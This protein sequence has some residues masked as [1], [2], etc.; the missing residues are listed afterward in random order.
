MLHDMTYLNGF[1]VMYNQCELVSLKWYVYGLAPDTNYSEKKTSSTKVTHPA[2]NTALIVYL[3]RLQQRNA[4]CVLTE[5]ASQE[6]P[7]ILLNKLWVFIVNNVHSGVPAEPPTG[8]CEMSTGSW[9]NKANCLDKSI[10]KHFFAA[11]ASNL[12]KK[13]VAREEFI[14]TEDGFYKPND[15]KFIFRCPSLT[16][17]NHVEVYLEETFPTPAFQLHFQLS[18]SSRLLI[19]TLDVVRRDDSSSEGDELGDPRCSWERLMGLPSQ[20][21]HS[22]VDVW[23]SK[24]GLVPRIIAQ[25]KYMNVVPWF[26]TVS[27]RKHQRR[28][29]E[30]D[31]SGDEDE[32]KK[33]DNEDDADEEEDSNHLETE[34]ETDEILR[35]PVTSGVMKTQRKRDSADSSETEESFIPVSPD[36]HVNTPLAAGS[37]V[38]MTLP[39]DDELDLHFDSEVKRFK[40]RRK[41]HKG[42][43][44]MEPAIS[45]TLGP[46]KLNGTTSGM[47]IVPCNGRKVISSSFAQH[48][49][50]TNPSFIKPDSTCTKLKK[51]TR[52][53]SVAVSLVE[54]LSHDE[55]QEALEG[56]PVKTHPLLQ[57]LQEYVDEE[58]EMTEKRYSTSVSAKIKY[59]PNAKTFIPPLQRDNVGRLS[60]NR[61]T[62]EQLRRRL[63]SNRFDYWKSK[64]TNLQY[65]RN[66]RQAKKEQQRRLL[67]SSLESKLEVQELSKRIGSLDQF[68]LRDGEISLG[69][70]MSASDA[71]V[72]WRQE[73]NGIEMWSAHTNYR[74]SAASAADKSDIIDR[75][76]PYLQSLTLLLRKEDRNERELQRSARDRRWMSFEEF[77]RATTMSSDAQR[78]DCCQVEEPKVCVSSLESSYQVEPAIISEYLLRDLHPVVAP[79]PIDYV[80]VCPQ[81]PSQW[82]ACLALSYFTCFRSMY[83]QC[84]MGDLASVDLNQVEGNHYVTVIASNGL[85]LVECAESVSDPFANFRAAGD[86]LHPILSSGAIK[87][88]QAFSRSAVATV[89]YLVVPFRRSDVKHKMW[90]LGAFS[91]GLFGTQDIDKVSKWKPSVTIEMLFLDD[92]YEVDVNPSPFV[93]MPNCFGLYDRVCENLTLKPCDGVVGVTGRSRFLSERLYH[94]A[95]WRTKTSSLDPDDQTER[96]FI[97]V[98]YLLSQ[99]RKWIACSCTDAVGSV[100]ETH[101]F[102]VKEKENGQGLEDALFKMMQNIV[103]FY[104]LFNEISELVITRLAGL[105][106]ASNLDDE[107]Q[108]AWKQ[109]RSN[110]LAKLISPTH[111]SLFSRI[112]LVQLTAVSCEEVQLHES[113]SS[114]TLYASDEVGF[115]VISPQENIP[116]RDSSRAV[117]YTGSDAWKSTTLMPGQHLLTHKREARILKAALVLVLFEKKFDAKNENVN[118]SASS[119]T[120]TIILRDFHAL[121]YLTMHPITM[122]RQSPLPYH[123]AAISKICRELQALETQLTTDPLQLRRH[124]AR[125]VLFL[126]S[127]CPK[128]LFEHD[129]KV[130]QNK[131]PS[132]QCCRQRYLQLADNMRGSKVIK[133]PVLGRRQ[134]SVSDDNIQNF[135]SRISGRN[136]VA[137]QNTATSSLN[138][139]RFASEPRKDSVTQLNEELARRQESYV[140]R[141]RQYKIRIGELEALLS[142]SRA[143][144]SKED[145]LEAAMERVRSMHRDILVSVNQV[146]DRT[147]EI[148]QEQ[149]KDLLR[150]FRARLFSVQEELESEKNR[151]DDGASAWIEKSKHLEN[152]VEWTKDLA[153]RLDRLNQSLTRENQRL[154]TQFATQ[155]NDREFLIK[156]LVTVKKDNASLRLE[157]GS[158]R[159]QLEELNSVQGQPLRHTFLPS[160]STSSLP[161]MRHCESM[162]TVALAKRPNTAELNTMTVS[163]QDNRYKEVIKRLKRLLEVERRKLQQVRAAY[164][165]ELQS[166]SELEAILRECVKDV[167]KETAY[168]SQLP[169]VI[170]SGEKRSENRL[171]TSE[172]QELVEKLMTKNQVLKLLTIKVFPARNGKHQMITMLKGKMGEQD[173]AINL[174][175]AEVSP[176]P[177]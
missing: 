14:L 101:V 133:P 86:V 95:D 42:T 108:I 51:D 173:D 141:E 24:D 28:T 98:S 167:R 125:N 74:V 71:M 112:L 47:K 38:L 50:S 102:P 124:D 25:T 63:Y 79:K 1:D 109:L 27:K 157:V 147:S 26:R 119:S 53:L 89:V 36:T 137:D 30:N 121:T 117:Y 48:M 100:L 17:L 128:I 104:L 68:K 72:T 166:H 56:R 114:T 126:G 146:Q 78:L 69:I 21:D 93:L 16:K 168:V 18:N 152:E 70:Q 12:S 155:E 58:S 172:R 115:V 142:D 96:P 46:I 127:K 175:S 55:Q 9:S 144:K 5:N 19:M 161:K 65:S 52:P 6:I 76:Q 165:L 62:A 22:V 139:Y 111:K 31:G 44:G 140:R 160:A 135:R 171:S 34:V 164:T 77:I 129:D 107:E 105:A 80:I 29:N 75:V 130:S 4:I 37:I 136:L 103:E 33:D 116:A 131:V 158:L 67:L 159:Q 153:D 151:T 170:S 94:L 64:Y 7:K 163:N 66:G 120:M 3:Q 57:A 143:K 87:K 32:V 88:K 73:P 13:L 60:I 148:L 90:V 23:H 132:S 15:A 2:E 156:Q 122:E 110:R 150:A 39:H 92:L 49:M 177:R 145:N 162:A 40:R 35:R 59:V 113:L 43:M 54:S 99:D 123:L 154:K 176:L 118:Q 169:P 138:E 8:V 11:L 174:H 85:V 84:H 61:A 45:L 20:K 106:G 91:S 97:H 41:G 82:L 10:Q 83:G 149:E 134:S 81:S